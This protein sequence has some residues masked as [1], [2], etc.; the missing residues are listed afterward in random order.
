MVASHLRYDMDHGAFV[1]VGHCTHHDWR[2]D[3]EQNLY[4]FAR[5]RIDDFSLLFQRVA[6]KAYS[7]FYARD[8]YRNFCF[9]PGR[10]SGRE[11]AAV[12]VAFMPIAL[13]MLR[14]IARSES[15]AS[16]TSSTIQS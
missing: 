4:F 2:H 6:H 9:V 3:I 14:R 8:L 16:A 15:T 12:V 1:D 5:T 10:R 7:R 13:P 11:L